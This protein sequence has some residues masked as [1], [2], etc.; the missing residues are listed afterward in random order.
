MSARLTLAL[1]FVLAGSAAAGGL[2]FEADFPHGQGAMLYDAAGFPTRPHLQYARLIPGTGVVLG[3]VQDEAGNLLKDVTV[4]ADVNGH[5]ALTH[6]DGSFVMLADP[7]TYE[8]TAEK[9]GY[10]SAATANIAV[11]DGGLSR[12]S[13]SLPQRLAREILLLA[14]LQPDEVL[15]PV[16]EQQLADGVGSIRESIG[17]TI[18]EFRR[19]AWLATTRHGV[20]VLDAQ[21]L[22]HLSAEAN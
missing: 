20:I 12:A 7:G 1:V 17:R 2:T 13:F 11:T 16:T 4:T 19:N 8:V 15:V 14:D 9:A 18:G 22:R 6:L 10:G 21:S 3:T 5:R